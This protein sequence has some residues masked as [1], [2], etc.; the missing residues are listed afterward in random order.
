MK[1]CGLPPPGWACSRESDHDGPCAARFVG[2]F[3]QRYSWH[4]PIWLALIGIGVATLFDFACPRHVDAQVLTPRWI[5]ARGVM[6]D[7][8][9]EGCYFRIGQW[10][11][12]VLHPNGESCKI[13]RNELVGKSIQLMAVVE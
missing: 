8:E 4:L 10:T 2:W 5:I 11:T 12:I 7:Y 3:A 1:Q 13:V 6:T 9:R